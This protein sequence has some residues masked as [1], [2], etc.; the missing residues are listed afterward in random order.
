MRPIKLG[1]LLLTL[2]APLAAQN[3]APAT[4]ASPAAE[5]QL[6]LGRQLSQW[7]L[8]GRMD[9][10]VARMPA[11]VKEKSGGA[12]GLQESFAQLSVRGGEESKLLEEKMTRRRGLAQYWRSAIY[13]NLEEPIVLRWLFDDSLHVVGM[14]LGP[15]S[16]T[17]AP[18]AE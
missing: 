2:A 16:R 3:P 9:S 14:G 11:D 17:P 5:Q 10:I 1:L 8:V 13:T 15:L 18:D 6:A 12:A 7:F 4:P